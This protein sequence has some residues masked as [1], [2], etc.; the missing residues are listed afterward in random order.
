VVSGEQL[1][2]AYNITESELIGHGGSNSCVEMS[3]MIYAD[4][5]HA[6]GFDELCD[7]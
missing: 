5:S 3:M 1:K 4:N 2:P 6:I 7:K